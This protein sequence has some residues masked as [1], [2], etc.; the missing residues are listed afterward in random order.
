MPWN[1][2]KPALS[3]LFTISDVSYK[4][5]SELIDFMDKRGIEIDRYNFQHLIF[6]GPRTHK[7]Q[8]EIFKK[9]FGIHKL[10]LWKGYTYLPARMDF[11]RFKAE[12]EKVKG[13]PNVQFSA[14]LRPEELEPYYRDQREA[15]HYANYCT[16]PWHQLNLMPNGE[17]FT[18]PGYFIGNIRGNRSLA[19]IWNGPKARKLRQYLTKRLFPGCKGCFY[20]YCDRVK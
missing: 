14:D 19:Q 17:L 20:Y 11:S 12:I 5:M 13:R 15:L 16:A 9:E 18:C 4:H 7:A 6:N 1:N 8:K 2:N 3:I 10:D